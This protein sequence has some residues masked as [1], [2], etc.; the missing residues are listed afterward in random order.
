MIYAFVLSLSVVVVPPLKPGVG[1][2]LLR[3][4]ANVLS[5]SITDVAAATTN[6]C[7]IPVGIQSLL[8][9]GWGNPM[10]RNDREPQYDCLQDPENCGENQNAPARA[11]AL[12][13][14][15]QNMANLTM[16]MPCSTM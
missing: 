6:T 14:S 5:N 12:F 3:S 9:S 11:D 10:R 8:V 16:R 2:K 4:A 7:R 15:A 1:Y 13:A